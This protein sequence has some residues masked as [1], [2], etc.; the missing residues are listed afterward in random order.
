[1]IQFTEHQWMGLILYIGLAWSFSMHLEQM[2]SACLYLWHL[3][4]EA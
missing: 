1:M 3:K 4:R 2:F